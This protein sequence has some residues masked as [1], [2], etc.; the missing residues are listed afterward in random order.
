MITKSITINTILILKKNEN[1][2]QAAKKLI[3]VIILSFGLSSLQ[4]QESIPAT[5]GEA[6]GAGSVSYTIGQ[7]LYTTQTG[8]NGNTVTNGVQQAYKILDVTGIAEAKGINLRVSTYPNPTTDYLTVKTGNYNT[9]KLQIKLFDI[10]GKL[11]QNIKTEGQET[12]IDMSNL[13]PATYFLKV[14]QRQGDVPQEVKT[15]RIIKN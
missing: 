11:L 5:G 8:T 7:V 10:N 1:M 3:T 2:I 4:S 14:V 9:A 13:V 15:F 6:T 12:S